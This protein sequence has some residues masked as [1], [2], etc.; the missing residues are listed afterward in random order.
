[1]GTLSMFEPSAAG[2]TTTLGIAGI[3]LIGGSIAL[4][5]RR[6]WP[7]LVIAGLDHP[8]VAARA[9]ADGVID[10]ACQRV[11]QLAD[12][13]LIVLASPITDIVAIVDRLATLGVDTLV[14]DVGSTKRRV[15]AAAARAG[16][17]RFVGGHPMA[18][19]AVGG[20][21]NATVDLFQDRPWILVPTDTTETADLERLRVF[22]AALGATP[23]VVGDADRHDRSMAYVSHLPQLLA[24]A[25]MNT[26]GEAV[27]AEG[28]ALA[29]P[30][31]REMTRLAASEG[32]LWR[33]IASDNA[34]HV[35][36]AAAALRAELEHLAASPLG[37]AFDA[38]FARANGW[39]RTLAR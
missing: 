30:A 37:A 12:C 5:A 4:A 20:L 13:S 6:A 33:G 34:D 22:V 1:M 21:G 10:R 26:A 28:L 14:T 9:A 16:L 3:G 24:V 27:G 15:L 36:I 31:F 8:D 19:A 35:E 17:A 11:E 18:G 7:E 39:R 29:G 25:L 2:A 23:L 38:A 32:A